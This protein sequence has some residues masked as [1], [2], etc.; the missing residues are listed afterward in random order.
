MYK[1]VPSFVP[2]HHP[3]LYFFILKTLPSRMAESVS[4]Y[5]LWF[6]QAEGSSLAP[7]KYSTFS[8]IPLY[9]YMNGEGR[10]KNQNV[11][12]SSAIWFQDET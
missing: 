2:K 5:A 10:S 9:P 7:T 6:P 3:F 11:M 8:F 4:R 12:E 1:T